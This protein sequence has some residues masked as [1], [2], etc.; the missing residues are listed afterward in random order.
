MGNRCWAES[1][2]DAGA[3]RGSAG[4]TTKGATLKSLT[5]LWICVLLFLTAVSCTCVRAPPATPPLAGAADR[6]S[7]KSGDERSPA[8]AGE[9][10]PS[11]CKSQPAACRVR[12]VPRTV[13]ATPST[14]GSLNG[15]ATQGTDGVLLMVGPR[16]HGVAARTA[17]R[18]GGSRQ[19]RCL[20]TY[21]KPPSRKGERRSITLSAISCCS[22]GCLPCRAPRCSSVYHT[23]SPAPVCPSNVSD[24]SGQYVRRPC[25]TARRR[26][27]RDD[28]KPLAEWGTGGSG[29]RSDLAHPAKEGRHGRSD[30]TEGRRAS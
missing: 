23:L 14:G 18:S 9:K 7:V 21:R 6:E 29:Q 22:L 1:M 24:F 2:I 3:A 28:R 19:W 8:P 12:G 10:P 20:T 30:R 16:R 13:E 11:R 15:G 5:A 4:E 26:L 17:G 27:R 25:T